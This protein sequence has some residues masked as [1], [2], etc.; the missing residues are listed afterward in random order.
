[1]HPGTVTTVTTVK[2]PFSPGGIRIHSETTLGTGSIQA[3]PHITALQTMVKQ[4]I[5]IDINVYIPTAP[6]AA[7]YSPHYHNT[8]TMKGLFKPA[9]Y[10]PDSYISS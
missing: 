2:I 7:F 10:V 6:G 8:S 5:A 9:S 4:G 3:R 1:M